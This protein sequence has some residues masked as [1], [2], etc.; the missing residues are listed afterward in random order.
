MSI[1]PA[2][3]HKKIKPII[4]PYYKFIKKQ[5]YYRLLKHTK[6]S[7]FQDDIIAK[8]LYLSLCIIVMYL[9]EVIKPNII[10]NN[11][12]ILMIIIIFPIT[13]IRN[14]DSYPEHRKVIMKIIGSVRWIFLG[15]FS[16]ILIQNVTDRKL[17]SDQTY[18]LV[19]P[20]LYYW[21]TTLTCYLLL[22]ICYKTVSIFKKYA[23]S[24]LIGISILF[25][26][27]I[28]HYYNNPDLYI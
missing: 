8:T 13:I 14:S 18:S 16:I 20:A 22:Y 5:M 11:L 17:I 2:Y 19:E 10:Y 15:P 26:V 9:V 4:K 28:H 21:I 6:E 24:Y 23:L 7:F 1:L 3:Y 27:V 25:H 12:L